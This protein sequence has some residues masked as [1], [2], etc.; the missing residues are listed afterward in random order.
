MKALTKGRVVYG[1]RPPTPKKIAQ[2]LQR[3]A[4]RG[5]GSKS[6]GNYEDDS[7]RIEVSPIEPSTGRDQGYFFQI[8][9][10]RGG[11]MV[12]V[13]EVV[14]DRERHRH[15]EKGYGAHKVPKELY[16]FIYSLDLQC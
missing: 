12:W 4:H 7:F 11:A 16:D 14:I 2:T 8:S 5:L 3:C 10:W 1:T 15:I 9:G 13:I 6:T